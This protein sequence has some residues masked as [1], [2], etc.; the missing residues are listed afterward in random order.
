MA[1]FEFG[2]AAAAAD[3]AESEAFVGE[4]GE[5]LPADGGEFEAA[6]GGERGEFRALPP[7]VLLLPPKLNA[8]F[9]S[10]PSLLAVADADQ[11]LGWSSDSLQSGQRSR[12][13]STPRVP[14]VIGRTKPATALVL[15]FDVVCAAEA[16]CT[17]L[18][19]PLPLEFEFALLEVV[20]AFDDAG[21]GS[22]CSRDSDDERGVSAGFGRFD[23]HAF[24]V[25]PFA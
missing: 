12:E 13:S 3:E 19:L 16:L 6:S 1:P 10:A 24:R 20:A 25:A 7:L 11:E 15:A 4:L 5:C 21:F 14:G 8:D 18:L 2:R 22:G 23:S 17:A 9:E